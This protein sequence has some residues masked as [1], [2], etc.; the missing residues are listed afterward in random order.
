MIKI[1]LAPNTE[2]ESHILWEALPEIVVLLLVSFTVYFGVDLYLDS[3]RSMIRAMEQS[4]TQ[5]TQA[6]AILMPKSKQFQ[7][8][9]KQYNTLKSRSLSIVEITESNSLRYRPVIA[10]EHIQTLKPEGVWLTGINIIRDTEKEGKYYAERSLEKIKSK[11][12]SVKESVYTFKDVDLYDVEVRG[13]AYDNILLAEFISTLKSTQLTDYFENDLR[14]KIFF[15]DFKLKNSKMALGNSSGIKFE[16]GTKK[17]GETPSVNMNVVEFL[18][19]MKIGEKEHA[20][21]PMNI[22]F[23]AKLDLR[24]QKL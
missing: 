13:Y 19:T 9:N 21:V 20:D 3:E 1:N 4:R 18:F 22:S 23:N 15:Q 8:L 6:N 7:E 17:A 2:T 12:S 11:Q 10:L 14:S 24:R 16:G 5:L